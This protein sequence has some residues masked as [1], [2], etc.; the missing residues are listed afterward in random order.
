MVDSNLLAV[1]AANKNITEN[2]IQNAQAIASDLLEKVYKEKYHFI[3]ANPPFHTGKEVNY[4]VTQAL[5]HQAFSALR[6]Q[7]KIILVANRFIRYDYQL[8]NIFH[9]VNVLAETNRYHV[10]SASKNV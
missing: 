5:L 4:D 2:K 7:G 3:V 1:A 10:L 9:N 8:K 6:P